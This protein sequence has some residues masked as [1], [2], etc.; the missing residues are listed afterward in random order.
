[1]IPLLLLLL[2]GA[3]AVLEFTAGPDGIT[4]FT[5]KQNPGGVTTNAPKLEQQLQF[6]NDFKD[7]AAQQ[8]PGALLMPGGR[9]CDGFIAWGCYSLL[10]CVE[11]QKQSYS[12]I[13]MSSV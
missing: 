6:A 4:T 9:I 13:H 11:H 1:M 2:Q 7:Q 5:W 12:Y 10:C 8:H 3:T